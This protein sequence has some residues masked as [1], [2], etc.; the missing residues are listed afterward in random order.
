VKG[1]KESLVISPINN[2]RNFAVVKDGIYYEQNRSRR[3][4][5]ILFYRFSDQR[6]QKVADVGRT[7]FEGLSVAPGGDWLLFSTLEEHPGNLWLVKDF[8]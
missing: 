6:S 1:G 3:E 7:G 5:E 4:L 8:R 2:L